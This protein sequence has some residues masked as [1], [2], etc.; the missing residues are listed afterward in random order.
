MAG[1]A[2]VM[3]VDDDKR[4]L[5]TLSL[6]L[7]WR[8]YNVDTASDGASALEKCRRNHY[9]V[10]IMGSGMPRMSGMEMLR[11]IR[12]IDSGARV[13]LMTAGYD[14]EEVRSAL[15]EGAYQAINKPVD[16]TKLIEILR[17]TITTGPVL[18]VGGQY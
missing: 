10:T 13:I 4:L 3:L 17:G 12:E 2:N 14:D 15:A 16:I 11:R 9:D 6:I 8:G 7:K 1:R 5:E 18:V